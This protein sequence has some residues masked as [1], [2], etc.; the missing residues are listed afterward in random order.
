MPLLDWER[1]GALDTSVMLLYQTGVHVASA[2][3]G[4]GK[5]KQ[6]PHC[7]RDDIGGKARPTMEK[8]H[9]QEWL[10]YKTEK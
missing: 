6:I 8:E 7:V 2:W 1:L 9:S 4:E 3:R 5:K 10:C